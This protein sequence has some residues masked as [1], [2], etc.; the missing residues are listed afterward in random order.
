MPEDKAKRLQKIRDRL[1]RLANE[2]REELQKH[3]GMGCGW[4]GSARNRIIDAT[5][6]ID[7]GIKLISK[8]DRP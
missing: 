6:D 5:N 3:T 1:V 2:L 4:I 8:Q 7:K